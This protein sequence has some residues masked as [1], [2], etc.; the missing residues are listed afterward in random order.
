M[1]KKNYS[2]ILFGTLFFFSCKK[3]PPIYQYD[4]TTGPMH[5]IIPEN[6]SESLTISIG[7]INMDSIIKSKLKTN[8]NKIG[9][10]ETT[11]LSAELQINEL[12]SLVQWS[13]FSTLGTIC[14][15]RKIFLGE[16]L[17][18]QVIDDTAKHYF[19]FYPKD[20]KKLSSIF[21]NKDSV[22]YQCTF[23]ARQINKTS[24]PC[25]IVFNYRIKMTELRR[26]DE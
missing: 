2:Y 22:F 6:N 11:L 24:I 26:A 5:F 4:V 8:I 18:E 25:Q 12:N 23:K 21:I 20:E 3:N 1:Y 19:I 7:P 14:L 15:D 17:K 16:L 13:H 10:I 9:A